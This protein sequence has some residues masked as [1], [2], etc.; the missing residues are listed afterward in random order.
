M[1]ENWI[2]TRELIYLNMILQGI[3]LIPYSVY[4]KY[5]IL[6]IAV[7]FP[8]ESEMKF[9]ASPDNWVKRR[10]ITQMTA[11]FVIIGLCGNL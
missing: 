6:V 11:L 2:K 9:G 1:N 3:F 4:D 5:T 7:T 8:M 10:Q